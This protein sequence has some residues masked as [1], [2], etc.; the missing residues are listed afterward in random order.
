MNGLK[1]LVG[2]KFSFK[3]DQNGGD[4][5]GDL[6]LVDELPSSTWIHPDGSV[7]PSE[8]PTETVSYSPADIEFVIAMGRKNYWK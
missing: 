3:R 1:D 5:S 6:Y 8:M 7:Q 4:Q 2:R